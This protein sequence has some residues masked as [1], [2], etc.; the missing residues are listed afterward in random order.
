MIRIPR[1]TLALVL[2]TG[3]PP[4]QEFCTLEA[5]SSIS[6]T[7]VDEDGFAI[8]EAT[9]SFT[10][11]RGD[12]Q[13]CDALGDPGS[14]VCGWEVAGEF[15]VTIEAPGFD[16]DTFTRR[17]ESDECH[18]ITEVVERTLSEIACTDIA[19]PS[20][21]VTVTDTQGAAIDSADV[22]W[23]MAAEDDLPE[24]C[25]SLGGNVWTC[26]EEQAGELAVEIS[27][28]GPY[29][30]FREVVNVEADECHVLTE[31]LS[32]VLEFLPD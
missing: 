32:A 1:S 29:Q 15:T 27:N 2:L 16:T 13:P 5:R 18:V 21:E 22:V 14:F 6:L 28:A 12:A 24:P 7:V 31:S 10:V 4:F 11:G 19:L 17:V 26:G 30:A 20:I 23:N 8:P 3:C 25:T 9:A